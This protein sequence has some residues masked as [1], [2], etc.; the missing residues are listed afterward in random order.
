MPEMFIMLEFWR[1]AP[2]VEK[3]SVRYVRS[4]KSPYESLRQ[5]AG[6]LELSKLWSLYAAN[7]SYSNLSFQ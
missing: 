6:N 5:S 4:D 2:S 3:Y 7:D 1:K